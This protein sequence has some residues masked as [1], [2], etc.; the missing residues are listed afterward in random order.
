MTQLALTRIE[1]TP[2]TLRDI[3]QAQVRDAII[4]GRFEP[5]ERLVERPLCEQL[6]VSRTV[7]RETIRF[8]E[9]EGL[10]EIIPNKGPIVAWLTR[11][12]AREIYEIRMQLETTAAEYCAKNMTDEL[13]GKLMA[14]FEDLKTA[15]SGGEPAV[16]LK[17]THHFY[18]TIFDGAQRKI[19]WEIVQRLTGRISRLRVMT[20]AYQ[21][22]ETIGID[23]MQCICSAICSGD[24][25]AARKA[26]KA[27]LSDAAKVAEKILAKA[28]GKG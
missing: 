23:H 15:S 22:R 7:V 20:L 9:A 14:A 5:G 4:E 16:L 28:D 21:D 11:D 24:A 13:S 8:L 10:V 1:H 25:V 3:V 6:G 26:V 27:H 19:S 17:A 2:K 12:Q 18:R